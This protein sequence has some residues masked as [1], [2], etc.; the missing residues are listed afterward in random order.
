M[1]APIRQRQL[2]AVAVP[3]DAPVLRSARRRGLYDRDIPT[4][5]AELFY[6]FRDH[7]TQPLLFH[8]VDTGFSFHGASS[9]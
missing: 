7:I 4:A 6:L 8:Y 2:V 1:S 9:E 5:I 3:I